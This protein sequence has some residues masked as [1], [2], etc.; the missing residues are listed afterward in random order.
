MLDELNL[1]VKEEVFKAV[2]NPNEDQIKAALRTHCFI[3]EK[4]NG[5]I[6][7]QAVIDGRTQ[8]RFRK[9]NIFTN[10][11]VGEHYA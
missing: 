3:M 7:A 5:R 11:E 10:S 1:F 6:S 9:R 4:R 2:K 8:R